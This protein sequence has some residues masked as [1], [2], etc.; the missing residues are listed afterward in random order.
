MHCRSGPWHLFFAIASMRPIQQQRG[1]AVIVVT[2]S[3][4]NCLRAV[5]SQVVGSCS[6][7]PRPFNVFL[8]APGT[9]NHRSLA[10]FLILKKEKLIITPCITQLAVRIF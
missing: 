5:F 2:V 9:H 7:L 10:T 8:L 6:I 1:R 4:P 3:V